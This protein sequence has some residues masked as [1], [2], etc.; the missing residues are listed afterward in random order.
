MAAA[1]ARRMPPPAHMQCANRRFVFQFMMFHGAWAVRVFDIPHRCWHY[2]QVVRA[3]REA[4]AAAL[5][6]P[7]LRLGC[8]AR[9][10]RPSVILLSQGHWLCM[11]IRV[12]YGPGRC[13]ASIARAP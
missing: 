3:S 6:D 5:R 10:D 7:R 13:E 1:A 12:Q 8:D 11:S 9:D 2:P 4:Y